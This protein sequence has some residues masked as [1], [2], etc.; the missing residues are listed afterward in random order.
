MKIKWRRYFLYYYGLSFG[1]LLFALPERVAIWLGAMAGRAAFWLAPKY[2]H[3]AIQNLTD[4]FGNERSAP[5][6]QKIARRVFENLGKNAAEFIN[7]PKLTRSNIGRKVAIE[8]RQYLDEALDSGRGVIVI[9][10]HFG[11]WELIASTF[12]LNGY[13]GAVIGRRIYF[14]KYDDLLNRLRRSTFVEVIYRDESPKKI[15]KVLKKNGIIGIL[16]DQDVDS[17]D[18]VFIDFL[19]KSAFTPSGP[20]QLARVSGAKLIP[21]VNIRDGVRHRIV[22]EEPLELETTDDKVRDLIVNTEKWSKV[23][24]RYIREY[25]EQWVWMHKRWKTEQKGR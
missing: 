24:E 8:N 21:C 3:I 5:Q 1:F 22:F 23:I 12:R 19:G 10:A 9:T 13:E 17:V 7:L 14:K 18:G 11:N 15:L 20:V 6:I 2:R 16:A 4:V 25:P